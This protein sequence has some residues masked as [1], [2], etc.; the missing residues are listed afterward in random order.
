MFPRCDHAI[1]AQ[2]PC[3]RNAVIGRSLHLSPLQPGWGWEPLNWSQT[4][5]INYTNIYWSLPW[6]ACLNW[7]PSALTC[8]IFSPLVNVNT[9]K[10]GKCISRDTY[11]PCMKE[12][13]SHAHN[14]TKQNE[15]NKWRK[16]NCMR[17]N[18]NTKDDWNKSNFVLIYVN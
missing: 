9:K 7:P 4:L 11:T 16:N 5:N 8:H 6:P 3:P 10:H 12:K 13:H 15:T 17:L 18:Q 14:T 2:S 1:P